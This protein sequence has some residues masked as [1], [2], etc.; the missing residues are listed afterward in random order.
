MDSLKRP[1]FRSPFS[2]GPV[3]RLSADLPLE[4]VEGSPVLPGLLLWALSLNEGDLLIASPSRGADRT[5]RSFASYREIVIGCAQS[6]SH[7]WPY[8][9]EAMRCGALAAVDRNG[10]IRLPDEAA[11]LVRPGRAVRLRAEG[12]R[13]RRQLTLSAAEGKGTA[14]FFVQAEYLLPVEP[15]L[16]VT[17][18]N[19]ALWALGLPAGERLLGEAYLADVRFAASAASLRAEGRGKRVAIDLEA[20]GALA[21]PDSLQVETVLRPQARVQLIVTLSPQPEFRITQWVEI[22][23]AF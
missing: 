4:I 16:R 9:E 15:G 13:F 6:C 11:A 21:L 17:F 23:P 5:E 22:D 7:P 20:G 8:I 10:V 2:L 1:P 18:P 14:E 19:E 3:R 12:D